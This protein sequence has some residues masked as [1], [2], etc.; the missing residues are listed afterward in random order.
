MLRSEL[1]PA[2][3]AAEARG[4]LEDLLG[5]LPERGAAPDRAGGALRG[6]WGWNKCPNRVNLLAGLSRQVVELGAEEGP[7][8]LLRCLRRQLSRPAG[9]HGVAVAGRAVRGAAKP[10]QG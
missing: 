9:L 3:V 10:C 8:A 5:A 2:E 6:R 7:A 4:R 1:W